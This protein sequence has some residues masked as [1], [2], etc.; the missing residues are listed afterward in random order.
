[1]IDIPAAAIAT[2]ISSSVAT[3]VALRINDYNSVSNFR[4]Q[5]D[6]ILKTAIQYPYLENPAFCDAWKENK[7]SEDERYIRYDH[8]CSLVFNY[9]ERLCKYHR[10]NISKIEKQLNVKAWIR[11]H[12]YSWQYPKGDPNENIDSYDK[13]FV[14]IIKQYIE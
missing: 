7:D 2:L 1:M 8:Y 3:I 10:F 11:R 6:N 13:R 12:K 4:D 9:L 14:N 5:L